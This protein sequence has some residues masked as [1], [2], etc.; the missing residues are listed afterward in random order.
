[1]TDRKMLVDTAVKARERAYSPYSKFC[2]GAALLCSDGEV[3]VGAN[4]ENSS[5]GGTICA[6][7]VAFTSAV[8]SGKRD[9]KA[10][11]IVGAPYGE[12]ISAFC[13]PCGICRQFMAEFCAGDF[14]VLLFDGKEIKG[15]TLDELLPAAFTKDDLGI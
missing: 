13:A 5:Y 9:F 14:E 4:V 3:I 7:R 10:I 1:M 15:Y 12:Q 8:V 2:V 6:E 11:A